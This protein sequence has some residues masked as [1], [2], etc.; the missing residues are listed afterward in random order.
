MV[1]SQERIVESSDDAMGAEAVTSGTMRSKVIENVAGVRE[2]VGTVEGIE[3]TLERY[4][5]VWR[6]EAD[7]DAGFS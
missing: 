6:L 5:C 3:G 1:P 2:D 4:V 7:A